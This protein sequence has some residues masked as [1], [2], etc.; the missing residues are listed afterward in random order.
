MSAIEITLRSQLAKY[1]EQYEQFQST[2]ESSNTIMNKFK[3]EMELVGQPQLYFCQLNFFNDSVML[4]CLI[5]NP[6]N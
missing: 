6:C 1:A 4:L 5:I 2:V 3:K